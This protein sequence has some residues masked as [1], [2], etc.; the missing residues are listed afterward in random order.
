MFRLVRNVALASVV[1]ALFQCSSGCAN[2]KEGP[3]HVQDSAEAEDHAASR[4]THAHER[5]SAEAGSA[6][7]GLNLDHI[8]SH[9]KEERADARDSFLASFRATEDKLVRILTRCPRTEEVVAIDA[10][11]PEALA[12]QILGEI[13]S[14][15]GVDGLVDRLLLCDSAIRNDQ[16][17][18]LSPQSFF[19]ASRA[20]TQIGKPA[21]AALLERLEDAKSNTEK[22]IVCW[23]MVQIEGPDAAAALIARSVKD[24]AG[25]LSIV[26]AIRRP[27]WEAR[28]V[29]P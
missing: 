12:V 10:D 8:E 3:K 28:V 21:V 2:S 16:D 24:A 29:V 23:T 17:E 18:Y 13:R 6:T 14:V 22:D 4:P 20:L 15:R 7:V 27:G 9:S 1:G 11:S 5:R 19:L 26:E 25:A